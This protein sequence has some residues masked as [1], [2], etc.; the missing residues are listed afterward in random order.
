MKKAGL[1]SPPFRKGLSIL[2]GHRPTHRPQAVVRPTDTPSAARRRLPVCRLPLPVRALIRTRLPANHCRAH[3]FYK[4]EQ[5]GVFSTSSNKP[6]YSR[7]VRKNRVFSTSP[8][9]P[10]YS[11]RATR[12]RRSCSDSGTPSHVKCSDHQKE[13]TEC[14]YGAPWYASVFASIPSIVGIITARR[15]SL[16]RARSGSSLNNQKAR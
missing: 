14:A 2:A 13:P 12:R 5:T 16:M 10:E 6:E 3:Y 9:K 4:S 11:R 15:S 8:N 1:S 7:Q